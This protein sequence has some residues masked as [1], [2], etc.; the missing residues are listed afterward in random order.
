MSPS[1]NARDEVRK[2]AYK[3]A[4]DGDEARRKREDKALDIQ[5]SRKDESLSRRRRD[6]TPSQNSAT[7]EKQV[8]RGFPIIG[9]FVV[10]K[11]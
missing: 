3:H 11:P 7:T 9:L 5:K 1:P 2:K 8:R 4:V 10:G 6:G